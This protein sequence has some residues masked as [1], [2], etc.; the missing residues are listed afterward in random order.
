MLFSCTRT[1]ISCTRYCM[2]YAAVYFMLTCSHRVRVC[3]TVHFGGAGC[4]FGLWRRNGKVRAVCGNLSFLCSL[5]GNLFQSDGYPKLLPSK[6]ATQCLDADW[7]SRMFVPPSQTKGKHKDN[8]TSKV[9]P[10]LV[11]RCY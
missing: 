3:A 4:P 9:N 7:K 5:H 10:R 1:H 6:A 2:C 8:Q 11:N